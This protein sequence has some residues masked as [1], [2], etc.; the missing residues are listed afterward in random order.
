[1]QFFFAGVP[2]FLSE[3]SI[4]QFSSSGAVNVWRLCPL[5][6]GMGFAMVMVSGVVAPYYNMI[7]AWAFVFLYHSF[8]TTLPW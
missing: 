4:G 2:L 1:M 5:F 6:R 8:T 3:M 7:I